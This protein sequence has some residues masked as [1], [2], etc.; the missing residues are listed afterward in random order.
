MVK[1]Q[2]TVVFV[3]GNLVGKDYHETMEF[4]DDS[5][6][7]KWLNIVNNQHEPDYFIKDFKP[8]NNA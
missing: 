4:I 2:F 3:K 1:Y 8:Q 6:A 5:T 7:L